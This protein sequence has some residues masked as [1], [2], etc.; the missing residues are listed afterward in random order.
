MVS[1]IY[2]INSDKFPVIVTDYDEAQTR[3]Q[4]ITKQPKTKVV[5]W[6]FKDIPKEVCNG[7]WLTNNNRAE[8][9]SM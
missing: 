1:Q 4:K 2:Y 8:K 9:L 5:W 7:G 6:Y 3:A